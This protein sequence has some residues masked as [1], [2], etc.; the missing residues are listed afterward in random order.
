[1][2]LLRICYDAQCLGLVSKAPQWSSGEGFLAERKHWNKI[3]FPIFSFIG[4]FLQ[5]DVVIA[6]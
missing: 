5:K 3:I 1:M 6:S 2:I 4:V